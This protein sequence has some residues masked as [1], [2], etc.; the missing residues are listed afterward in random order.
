VVLSSEIQWRGIFEA[1]GRPD[2][3]L[4]YPFNSQAGRQEF[5]FDL[6]ELLQEWAS[7]Y[8]AEELFHLIQQNKSACAPTYT[9]E[10]FC[11]S[12]Q[13][14]AREFMLEIEHPVA[15]KLKYPGW[16]Y[17]FSNISW[18]TTQPAPL[19]GQHNETVFCERLGYT[20]QDLV[21]LKEAG[22]I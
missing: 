18:R 17:Q 12:P 7:N 2:W 15:G 9:A 13:T 1:M 22:V 10:Q 8:T 21:T 16:P 20:K 5:F 3:G 19:L 14:K 4:E 11:N 6:L